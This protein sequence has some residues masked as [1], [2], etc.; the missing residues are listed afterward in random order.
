M[1]SP[2]H[3]HDIVRVDEFLRDE[4]SEIAEANDANL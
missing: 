4:L 2:T 3:G 1:V